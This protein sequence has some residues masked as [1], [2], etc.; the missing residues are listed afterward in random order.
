MINIIKFEADIYSCIFDTWNETVEPW[1]RERFL[2][3]LNTGK[4]VRIP[5]DIFIAASDDGKYIVQSTDEYKDGELKNRTIKALNTETM[6]ETVIVSSGEKA[7][8]PMLHVDFSDD[9]RFIISYRYNENGESGGWDMPGAEWVLFDTVSCSTVNGK[10]K[11]IRFTEN[12]DAVIVRDNEG[13]KILLLADLSDVTSEYKLKTYEKYEL[14][15][16]YV[17]GVASLRL[18]LLFGDSSDILIADN[19]AAYSVWSGYLYIYEYDSNDI[20]VYSFEK[21][22][23][24]RCEIDN[25]IMPNESFDVISV[26]VFDSGRKCNIITWDNPLE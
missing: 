9:G 20:L 18:S 14:I 11:I 25:T 23:A 5:L 15:D 24:F 16:S 19:V 3:D 1:V 26:F 6:K 12:N 7:S 17:D 21:N 4:K 13:A 22:E 10:G 2:I 8:L